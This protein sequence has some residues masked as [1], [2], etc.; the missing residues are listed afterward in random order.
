M[1]KKGWQV[2]LSFC[3]LVVH[4]IS[5]IREYILNSY[6]SECKD[7]SCERSWHTTTSRSQYDYKTKPQRTN[8]SEIRIRGHQHVQASK[9]KGE[10]DVCIRVDDAH[11]TSWREQYGGNNMAQTSSNFLNLLP[12]SNSPENLHIEGNCTRKNAF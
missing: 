8:A 2:I 11:S 3:K 10:G 5:L 9:K 4:K 12:I 1:C 6:V 7:R